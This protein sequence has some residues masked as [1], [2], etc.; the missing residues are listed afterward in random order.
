M[1]IDA[2]DAWGLEE[3]G[4][5]FIDD[6]GNIEGYLAVNSGDPTG[7]AA[8]INTWVFAQNQLLYY[9]FGSGDNDWRQIR[10]NDIAFDPIGSTLISVTTDAAIKELS[11]NLNILSYVDKIIDTVGLLSNSS[12]P[13][14]YLTLNATVPVDGDYKVN[15]NYLWS[16]NTGSQ[17]FI[18][19]LRVNGTT[20]WHHQQEPK[21]AAGSGVVLPTT[22]GGTQNS[23]T[24]QRHP[25]KISEIVNLNA[26]A[27]S[28]DIQFY[29]SNNNNRA[30]IYKGLISISKW[31]LS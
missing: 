20:L 19:D 7:I 25:A 6:D 17:D 13:F 3:K 23:G 2:N 22:T 16:L 24:N 9:K 31:G 21:D 28:I 18:A 26:G 11:T 29:S 4:L 12:T 27:N 8:P 30:S 14:T 5:A 15:W 1:A 10:A